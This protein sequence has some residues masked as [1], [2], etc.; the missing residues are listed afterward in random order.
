MAQP[1]ASTLD[2]NIPC[3]DLLSEFPNVTKPISFKETP[4]YS[5]AHH[6]ESTGSP[7][8]AKA[9][10]LQSDR[11][12]RVKEEFQTMMNMGICRPS[13]RPWISPLHVVPKKDGQSSM[14]RLSTSQRS[15]ET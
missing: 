14:W 1:S 8:F 10:P 6:I 13:K 12:R 7:V 5:V 9:R 11:Y 4:F 15:Y 2:K 3:L